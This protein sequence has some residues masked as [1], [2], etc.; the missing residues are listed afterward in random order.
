[1]HLSLRSKRKK[2]FRMTR[3]FFVSLLV[4]FFFGYALKSMALESE[5]ILATPAEISLAPNI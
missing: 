4:G 2:E 1:M 3:V 5:R